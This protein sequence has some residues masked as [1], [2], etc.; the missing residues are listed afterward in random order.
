M[1]DLE[2]YYAILEIRPS[3]S[4]EQVVKARGILIRVWHPDRFSNDQ[5][6]HQRALGKNQGD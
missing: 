2:H 4:L 1:D 6:M 5:E 3:A